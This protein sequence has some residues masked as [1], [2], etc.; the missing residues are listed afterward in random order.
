MVKYIKNN[1]FLRKLQILIRKLQVSFVGEEKWEEK[2][3]IKAIGVKPNLN[4]PT[5]L[6]EK[7]AWLKINYIKDFYLECSDKYLVHGYL[8]KKL[9]KDYAPPLLY[10]T[11]S[12]KDL[13][14]SNIKEFPCIIKVSN[15][16]GSNLIV[17]SVSEYTEK[18]LQQYFRIEMLKAE[19]HTI[20]S[21]EHQYEIKKPYIVVEKL[22]QDGKGGI[23]NDYKFLYLNGKLE[24]IYCSVDRLGSNVR[25]IYD[26]GWNRLHF[27]WVA[28]ADERTFSMYDNS[29]SIPQ[30]QTFE[31]M[32]ELSEII[33]RD[34]PL[35]RVDFYETG[36]DVYIGEI[37]LHHGSGHDKFYPE[38]Y[39][40][41]YGSK[42]TLPSPNRKH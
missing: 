39:D 21:L 27:A 34:F 15:G 2:R 17:N 40:N 14:F 9:G 33:A 19:L 11:Q 30:P 41:L 36:N 10:V 32:K 6:N 28:G 16:S 24:F 3:Y 5:T 38:D 26:S 42:L 31:K 35:V 4:A 18:Y 23:P 8:K 20:S 29:P 7:I 25:Q 13:T 37:T 1:V 12:P 22:L